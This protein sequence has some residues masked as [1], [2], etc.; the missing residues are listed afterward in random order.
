MEDR[1]Q[2]EVEYYDK[3]SK[4]TLEKGFKK[5]DAGDFE[6]FNPQDLSSFKLFYE[7]LKDNCQGKL[8]LDYGCGNGVH[9]AYPLR[10]GAKRV[11]GIDLSEKSLE[12]ARNRAKKEGFGDK[13]D[14]L[15]MD[16]EKMDFPNDYFD[17]IMD[18]GTFSSLDLKRVYPELVRVLKP[19]GILVGIET[20]GHNPLSNFKRKLNEVFGKR[21]SWAAG[22]IF[23]EKDLKE[24]DKY[25]SET[26]AYFFHPIS[27]LAFPFLRFPGGK[28]IL[29]IF[30]LV[31]RLLLIFSFFRKYSFK[32]VFIFKGPKKN[33]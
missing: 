8:V 16:C 30:E 33:A 23:K 31:D 18:G 9:S 14:F 22:H 20:F 24:A 15:K 6:G 7:L 19:E 25:F 2:K 10:V 3:K 29:R 28:I 11:V 1:K 26:K 5:K 32:V 12:I 4:E 27:F 17:L 21:T 13:T